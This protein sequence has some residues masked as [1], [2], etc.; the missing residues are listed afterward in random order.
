MSELAGQTD[1]FVFFHRSDRLLRK[2]TN[3]RQRQQ[4]ANLKAQFRRA[5]EDNVRFFGFKC[6]ETP[7]SVSLH[8]HGLQQDENPQL[9]PVVKAYLDALE[10]IAYAD[11]R[12]VEHLVV[13]Q[14]AWDHP[15]MTGVKGAS[16]DTSTGAAV[17]IQV[18]RIEDY[19]ARFDRAYRSSFWRR[20]GSTPWKG[21]WGFGDEIKLAEQR[22]LAAR[23]P[24]KANGELLRMREENKLRDGFFADIDRPGPLPKVTQAI[25]RLIP[26]PKLHHSL[27]VRSG[28]TLMLPLR[29]QG[30]GSGSPWEE[31]RDAAIHRFAATQP[32]LP[33][34]GF[35]ALDI[36]VRGESVHGKDLDNLAH[37]LLVPIEDKLCVKRG[38]VVGYR[39]YSA[40]GY[41]EGIQVRIIDH[42][43]LID[44][45]V[46]LSKTDLDPS[47][48]LRL[49]RWAE[50]HRSTS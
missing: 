44:L 8:V 41:P 15:W 22:R 45:D 36:A 39:A 32:G 46:S 6:F 27:R 20:G 34:E 12:Q 23:A 13:Q 48:L 43:R 4:A 1:R 49:E 30:K 10:G 33:L 3:R 17:F 42:G 2:G 50:R 19:T 9:P 24:E 25:H 29:G 47:P 14:D 16:D 35:V 40:L 7:V 5:A 18:E 38:T 28:S 37:L 26:L 21:N 31:A 11:D